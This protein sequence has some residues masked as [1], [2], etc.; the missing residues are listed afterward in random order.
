MRIAEHALLTDADRRAIAYNDSL[1]QRRV[2][3]LIHI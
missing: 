1:D 3:S 2:L